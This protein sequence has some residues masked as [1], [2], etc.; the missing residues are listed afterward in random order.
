MSDDSIQVPDQWK[1]LRVETWEGSILLFGPV[2]AGKSTFGRYLFHRLLETH[3]TAAYLDADLGQQTIGPP[4]T[5]GLALRDNAP[6]DSV[7]DK[8]FPPGGRHL[9]RF[10]G[11]NTPRGHFLPL[12]LGMHKLQL[13]AMEKGATAIVINTSGFINPM[14]GAA[15]LKWAMVELLKPTRVVAFPQEREMEPILAPLRRLMGSSLCLLTPAPGI[16]IRTDEDRKSFRSQQY[17]AYFQDAQVVGLSYK[18]LAVFPN[19]TFY[20]GQLL[21]LDGAAGYTMAL[22]IIEK[23]DID[24]QALWIRTP[25]WGNGKVTTLRLGSLKLDNE[26]Y[27]DESI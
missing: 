24:E 2:D 3:K 9:H 14:H 13:A 8:S 1:N 16:V 25:W 26:S 17:Q 18:H 27:L 23:I 7:E 21:G 19:R 10:V 6:G 11:S 12:L 22:G 20:P 5:L 4:A 15:V